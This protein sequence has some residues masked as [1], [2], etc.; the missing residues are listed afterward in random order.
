MKQVVGL[1]FH[2]RSRRRADAEPIEPQ[3]IAAGDP[4]LRVE[5]QKLGQRVLL[6]AIEHVAL[7]LGDDQ[8]KARD[9]GRKI[10]QLDPAKIG[11]RN[12]GAPIRLRRAAG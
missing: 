4:V 3:G 5:R 6:A 8:R 1:I 9:L 7:I 2:A 11:Q 12:F 10:A